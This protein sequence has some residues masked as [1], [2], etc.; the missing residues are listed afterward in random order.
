MQYGF[1]Y[2][3]SFDLWTSCLERILFLIMKGYPTTNFRSFVNSITTLNGNNK[4]FLMW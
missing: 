4:G 2:L 3:L 1:C